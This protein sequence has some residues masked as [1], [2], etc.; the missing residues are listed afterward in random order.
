[1]S[2]Q[3]HAGEAHYRHYSVYSVYSDDSA[4]S[5]TRLT[6]KVRRMGNA[7]SVIDEIDD[8]YE[9]TL[10]RQTLN[11]RPLKQHPSWKL[12]GQADWTRHSSKVHRRIQR[13]RE[14]EWF[15]DKTLGFALSRFDPEEGAGDDWECTHVL[16]QGSFGVVGL[17]QRADERGH[18]VDVS[19]TY[20]LKSKL[21]ASVCCDKADRRRQALPTSFVP[22]V[23]DPNGSIVHV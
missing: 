19:K 1:M 17:W 10:P 22:R 20:D 21:T 6:S 18:T 9:R 13:W 7:N 2:E 4:S 12:R 11:L 8:A 3:V 23:Q 16:G 15:S 14:K 5:L